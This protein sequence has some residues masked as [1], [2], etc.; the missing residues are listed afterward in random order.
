M[1]ILGIE[2]SCDETAA[3]VLEAKGGLRSPKFKIL[4]NIISSQVKLHRKYGGV[5]PNLASREH[6][7]NL[8]IVLELALKEA[9]KSLKEI[10]LIVATR[11]PGLIPCLLVGVNFAKTL[12]YA[13]K[14]PIL[15]V[16]HLE[17]HLV[18]NWL[19]PTANPKFQ[20]ANYKQKVI[21]FPALCLIVSG[22][23]TLLVLMK[24]L[25][26]YRV[27]GETRDDA[28]GEAFD[29]VA[30]LLG[31]SYPGGAALAK[32]AEKGDK[33]AISF[34]RPMLDAKNYDFSFS[35]LKTSVLYHI[36][37]RSRLSKKER[38]DIAASFQEAVVEVLREKTL[39]AAREFRVKTIMVSGGVSANL[40]LR[41]AFINDKLKTK[42]EERQ[43]FF[44]AKDLTTDNAAM[45]AAAG[46]VQY[47]KSGPAKNLLKLDADANLSLPR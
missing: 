7:K 8:P 41:E 43:I 37:E 31:L 26:D 44:P 11:G 2:T 18:S 39:R 47:L 19:A 27:I 40:R 42:N 17:G 32:L 20:I 4:S 15:G 6:V 9:K 35:G 45:I 14:K 21:R 1:L 25:G 12:A 29:K 13:A 22:G 16:N 46:Y 24:K 23:H 34:P 5:V 36:Q 30:R 28:A 38:A 10:D 33:Q 3:S